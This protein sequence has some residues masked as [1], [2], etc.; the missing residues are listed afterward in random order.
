M[1]SKT[2]IDLFVDFAEHMENKESGYKARIAR[3]QEAEQRAA[4]AFRIS[5]IEKYGSE[6]AAKSSTIIE[7]AIESAAAPFR[8]R[9]YKTYAN[10]RFLDDTLDGWIELD[11]LEEAPDRVRRAVEVAWPMP[12]TITEAKAEAEMWEERNGELAAVYCNY[13]CRDSSDLSLACQ[14][15][16]LIVVELLET[17]LRATSLADVLTRFR[18]C[19]EY[20]D[21]KDPIEQALLADLEHLATIIA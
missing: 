11:G 14:L 9:K 18:E 17:K 12:S 3:E 16:Q 7:Q 21:G 2:Q 4:A 15:R 10:G 13:D 1:T 20:R 6:E 19:L 5:V 8:K